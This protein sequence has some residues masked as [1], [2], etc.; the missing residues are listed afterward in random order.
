[1]NPEDSTQISKVCMF[2]LISQLIMDFCMTL[3]LEALLWQ[4]IRRVCAV[5]LIMMIFP[6][7]LHV[8]Q[9]ITLL[10]VNVCILND[11]ERAKTQ[12]IGRIGEEKY[13]NSCTFP[14]CVPE[15]ESS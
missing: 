15:E 3:L 7:F 2:E 11:C 14:L 10:Y 9:T 4:I 6:G 1:M 5:V 13:N 8:C 12:K